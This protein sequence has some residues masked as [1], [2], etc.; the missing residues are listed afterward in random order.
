[1]TYGTQATRVREQRVEIE[2]E[3]AVV[4]GCVREVAAVGRDE[5]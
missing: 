2:P 4:A 1:V 5:V 3:V